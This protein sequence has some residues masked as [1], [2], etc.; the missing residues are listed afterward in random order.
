MADPSVSIK[1]QTSHVMVVIEM[2][3]GGGGSTEVEVGVMA[4]AT[5]AI[6]TVA[7]ETEVVVVEAL[8][9]VGVVVGAGG[10]GVARMEV[11]GAEISF[12]D[13]IKDVPNGLSMVE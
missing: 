9:A 12:T 4:I 13:F 5:V 7:I 3:A 11:K 6:A 1:P 2:V 8:M 10:R